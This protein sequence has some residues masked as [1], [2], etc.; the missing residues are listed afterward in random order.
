MAEKP[1]LG[2]GPI[3]L[4]ESGKQY[5]IPLS[6][7]YFDSTGKLK[8]DRWPSYPSIASEVD[9]FLARL[10]V[11]GA[12]AVGPEPAAKPA[13]LVKAAGAGSTGNSV[14]L[15]IENVAPD[16]NNPPASKADITVTETDT[17]SNV[18]PA[19]LAALIGTSAGGGSKPGLVF[20]SSA[21]PELPKAKS[22]TFTAAT[23]GTDP[24]T[25]KIE[26]NSGTGDAFTLESRS[27]ATDANLTKAEIK[28]VDATAGTFTMVVTWTKK[29]TA[30]QV[31]SVATPLSYAVVITA[32]PGG[33]RAPVPG[34]VTLSG[35]SD[36]TTTSAATAS[37]SAIAA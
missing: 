23:P 16:T 28:N 17:Y 35:G 27:K 30:T 37:G 21:N 3:S 6:A 5:S 31:D 22:Y 8:A 18:K 34:V 19:D 20:L 15:L 1:V 14:T 10:L 2:S 33:Y 12:L 29:V 9:T 24:A 11:S 26:K 32:P 4:L 13:F 25:A 36:A 7:L